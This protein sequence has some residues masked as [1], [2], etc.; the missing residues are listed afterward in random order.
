MKTVILPRIEPLAALDSTITDILTDKGVEIPIDCSPWEKDYPTDAKATVHAAHDGKRLYFLFSCTTD[1]IRAENTADQ[2]PVSDDSC[3]EAF[4]QP[5]EDGEYWN[6]EVNCTG[7]INASHRIE[8]PHATKL[9]PAELA[10]IWRFAGNYRTS[11][12]RTSWRQLIAVPLSLMETSY[13]PGMTMRANFY[14]CAAKA[15]KPY[16]LCWN[17]IES[18]KPNYHQPKFFGRIQLQ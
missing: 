12:E 2:S 8:K 4:I 9:T 17:N 16:F 7:A 1:E 3:V 13:S 18:E 14:A 10:Q 15:E 5:V 6:L 11:Q